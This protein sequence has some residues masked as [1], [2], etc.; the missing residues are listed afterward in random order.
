MVKNMNVANNKRYRINEQEIKA[1]FFEILKENPNGNVTVKSIC[2]K[3]G[4]NRSTFYAHFGDV[5]EVA[6]STERELADEFTEMFSEK[7]DDASIPFSHR[8]FC[9]LISFLKQHREFYSVK[10]ERFFPNYGNVSGLLERMTDRGKMQLRDVDS[11][12]KR[13]CLAFFMSGL[14]GILRHW[15]DEGCKTDTD[16]LADVIM[17]CVPDCLRDSRSRM[18]TGAA[19]GNRVSRTV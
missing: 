8:S 7:S 3:T 12:E 13:R 1:A 9:V 4:M 15:L 10:S 16:E 19:T 5:Y 14:C 2:E 11:A 6:E 18:G 17:K